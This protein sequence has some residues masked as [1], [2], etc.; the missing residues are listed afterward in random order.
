[1][2][3]DFS[4]APPDA[5]SVQLFDRGVDGYGNPTARY[6]LIWSNGLQGEEHHGGQFRTLQRVQTHYGNGVDGGTVVAET[7]FKGAAYALTPDSV[8]DTGRACSFTLTRDPE[9][10]S[11][12]VI[13]RAERGGPCRGEVTAVFPTLPASRD[14]HEVTVYA[15]TGQH[16]GGSRGWYQ[17]TR[18]ATPAEYANLKS[19]LES[20]G[21]RV[22]VKKRWTP[23]HDLTRQAELIAQRERAALSH[24]E[25][26]V[27]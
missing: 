27:S 7:Y 10:E 2:Q 5:I 18:A 26:K 17:Q 13:F 12:P 4:L 23:T 22:D 20:L 8:N 25:K 3:R 9:R 6:L 24:L 19:E 14:G 11:V 15:R 1:M 21:Y 16:S